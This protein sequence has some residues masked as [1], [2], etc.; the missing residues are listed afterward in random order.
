MAEPQT[1]SKTAPTAASTRT[2]VPDE[3]PVHAAM[4]RKLT[5]AFAPIT[6]TIRDESYKHSGHMGYMGDDAE[7]HFVLTIVSERFEGLSRLDRQRAIHK[8]LKDELATSIHALAIRASAP[9]DTKG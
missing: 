4:Q 8:A 9:S 7:T 3:R 1:P 2:P 6:L 5:D